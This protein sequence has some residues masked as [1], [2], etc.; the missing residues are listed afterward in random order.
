[1]KATRDE[2]CAADESPRARASFECRAEK[3]FLT[4]SSTL[5]LT[6]TQ[7][8][9]ADRT[10]ASLALKE[11]GVAEGS[12]LGVCLSLRG[13]RETRSL[14]GDLWMCRMC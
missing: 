8:I 9:A 1:M 11:W 7:R 13:I 4:P 3:R 5:P 6:S 2:L 12:D 14:R 10:K